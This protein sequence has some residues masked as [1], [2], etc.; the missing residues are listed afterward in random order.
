MW[1]PLQVPA[2]GMEDKN[3][4]GSELFRFVVFVEH[5]EDNIPDS[6]KQAVKEGTVL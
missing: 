4:P 1:I 5:A 6:G 2:K 3:E